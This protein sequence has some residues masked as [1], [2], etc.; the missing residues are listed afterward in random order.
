M[1]DSLSLILLMKESIYV[2]NNR[3]EK[4]PFSLRKVYQ[5]ARRVG[6]SEKTAKKISKIIEKQVY[7]GIKTSKIFKKIKNLLKKES[8]KLSIKFSL[9]EGLRKLGPAGFLFE[10]FIGE[11]FKKQGYRVKLNLSLKGYCLEYETDFLAK[12]KNLVYIGECKFRNLPEEGLVHSKT[13]LAFWAKIL[14]FKKGDFSKNEFKKNKIRPILVTNAKFSGS[15][16]KY[17]KCVGIKLLGWRCPK[18]NGLEKIIDENSFY[19]I[20]ILPSFK[21]AL[22]PAFVKKKIILVKDVLKIKPGKFSKETGISQKTLNSLIKEVKILL[23]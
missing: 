5:S 11:I 14:D 23:N 15:T 8:P 7:P 20:T 1:E 3:G 17:S 4:E 18:T 12:K 13:A 10:K 9:K 21:K 19:P 16:A 22:I 2:V 6:A